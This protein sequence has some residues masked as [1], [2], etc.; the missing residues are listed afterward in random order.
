MNEPKK[1]WEKLLLF[2]IMPIFDCFKRIVKSLIE[3]K[4][5]LLLAGVYI[6]FHELFEE[7]FTAKVVKYILFKCVS[8]SWNDVVFGVIL[9]WA[10]ILS[11]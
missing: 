7:L 5:I 4:L 2:V 10:V 11:V 1:W 3:N 6:I 8:S 9:L